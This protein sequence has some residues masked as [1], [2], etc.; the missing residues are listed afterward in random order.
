MPMFRGATEP[1]G[2]FIIVASFCQD[3]PQRVVKRT[4]LPQV[5]LTHQ[6]LIRSRSFQLL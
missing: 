4:S 1:L 2:G 5:I 3:Q 6:T